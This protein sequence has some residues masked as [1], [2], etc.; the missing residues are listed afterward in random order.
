MLPAAGV[1]S[2]LT[3]DQ[4]SLI[5]DLAERGDDE[6]PLA[7]FLQ[8]AIPLLPDDALPRIEALAFTRPGNRTAVRAAL[9]LRK[10][11][12][13]T[14]VLAD[15]TGNINSW[16]DTD[17]A[18]GVEALCMLVPHMP[19]S[20]SQVLAT[21]AGLSDESQRGY[22]LQKVAPHLDP[23]FIPDVLAAIG[24]PHVGVSVLTTLVAHAPDID[25]PALIRAALQTFED[26][27]PASERALAELAPHLSANQLLDALSVVHIGPI[28][29]S[30]RSW[31]VLRNCPNTTFSCTSC[32]SCS[33]RTPGAAVSRSSLPACRHSA[34]S[35]DRT[36][37]PSRANRWP[38]SADGGPDTRG[39]L[40]RRGS[41]LQERNRRR[42]QLV[43]HGRR[44]RRADR[45]SFRAARAL[46]DLLVEQGA[47]RYPA[48]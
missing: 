14:D 28:N 44:V 10:R 27:H 11:T 35:A 46:V 25:R 48:Q 7:T 21:A 13:L 5:L 4:V 16:Q 15:I 45:G 42:R 33:D 32:A 22:L 29:T 26:A 8:Q 2:Y 9:A 47:G 3:P 19:E 34:T 6:N 38:R 40:S 31:T 24:D 43:N 17:F 12:G 18:W 30:S 37:P 1:L 23:R 41:L 39:T 20:H 36:W